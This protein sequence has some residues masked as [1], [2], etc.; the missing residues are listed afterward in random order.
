MKA[1]PK[2]ISNRSNQVY[3]LPDAPKGKFLICP[4][5]IV[6][7]LMPITFIPKQNLLL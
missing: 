1:I 5:I 2:V 3:I 6:T 7:V 4:Y